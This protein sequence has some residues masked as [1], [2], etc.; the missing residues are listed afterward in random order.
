MKCGGVVLGTAVHHAAVD[1]FSMSHFLQTWS[2]FCR[3]GDGAAVEL[4]CHDRTPLLR[5]R[6]PPVVHPK[7][8]TVLFPK[9]TF[10]EQLGPNTTETFA[11]SKN[12]LATLKHICGGA[13][14]FCSVSALVWQCISIVRC[15]PPDAQPRLSFPVNVRRRLRPP[16]PQR[17]FGNALVWLGATELVRQ[18]ASE[19]LAS[20]AGR[21]TGTLTKMDDELVRSAIDYAVLAKIDRRPLKGSMPE[22]DIRITSW[23]GMPL[24][25]ADFGW[26]K[27]RIMS[28]AESVRGGFVYLMDDG[29]SGASGTGAVRVVICMEA[30]NI[31][32]FERL[33]YAN[34][35]NEARL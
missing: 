18:I 6:S 4:P 22:T 21:I 3:N 24:Y 25:D 8:L 5:P 10:S 28:R 26:G 30:A 14:T 17:Y 1:G 32:K 16:L 9:V 35:A 20:V 23:L 33:F 29:P 7:A 31:R 11:I 2:A 12:Q 19:P 34:I 27:P 15:L 13:S